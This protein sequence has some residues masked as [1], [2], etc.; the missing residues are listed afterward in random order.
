MQWP[1]TTGPTSSRLQ[2]FDSATGLDPRGRDRQAA[3][4]VLVPRSHGDF[5]AKG[6]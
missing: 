4:N 6:S 5:D 1:R 2:P 3:S